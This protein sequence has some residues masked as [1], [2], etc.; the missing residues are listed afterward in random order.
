MV[1]PRRYG[2]Q[3]RRTESRRSTSLGNQLAKILPKNLRE[4]AASAILP[5]DLARLAHHLPLLRRV[6]LFLH[7]ARE[8]DHV[9]RDRLVPHLALNEEA[10]LRAGASKIIR[11]PVELRPLRVELVHTDLAGAGNRLIGRY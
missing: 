8:R 2:S 6:A 10:G 7:G 9:A 5:E 1:P 3:L 4:F 11:A